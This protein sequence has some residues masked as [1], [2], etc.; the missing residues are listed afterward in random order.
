MKARLRPCVL[1]NNLFLAV[2]ENNVGLEEHL[3]RSPDRRFPY[4]RKSPPSPAPGVTEAGEGLHL[5]PLQVPDGPGQ[6]S[7]AF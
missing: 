3:R 1:L 6:L 2:K 5:G 7:L 4:A